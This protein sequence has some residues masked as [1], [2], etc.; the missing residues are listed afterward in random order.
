VQ[1][2]A[3]FDAAFGAVGGRDRGR[4]F[5]DAFGRD[6]PSRQGGIPELGVLVRGVP[7]NLSGYVSEAMCSAWRSAIMIVG[8]CV[9]PEGTFGMI[10]ASATL[11]ASVP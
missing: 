8:M 5:W 7:L 3:V 2:N 4:S 6:R 9:N 1:P 10:D 11:S